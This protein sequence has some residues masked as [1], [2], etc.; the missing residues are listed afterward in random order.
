MVGDADVKKMD[1]IRGLKAGQYIAKPM[2]EAVGVMS[3]VVQRVQKEKQTSAL[4]MEVAEDAVMKVVIEL[5]EENLGC[6][7]G[8]VVAK[9]VKKKDALK[10]RKVTLDS[11]FLMEVGDG[12]NLLI[13]QKVPRGVLCIV[14]LTGEAK[15]VSY[16]GAIKV[17]K[18]APLCAKGMV[19]VKDVCLREVGFVQKVC[20]EVPNFV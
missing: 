12:A 11:V 9:D 10:V 14:K 5:L 18:A 7:Y 20:M 13:A 16:Q 17:Q 6:V 1:A 15:D 19:E 2:V 4:L 3:L 8:M